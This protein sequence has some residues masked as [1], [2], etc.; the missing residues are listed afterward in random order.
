M[1]GPSS[2]GGSEFRFK[3]QELITS[4]QILD[5]TIEET[6]PLE[7]WQRLDDARNRLGDLTRVFEESGTGAQLAAS[8]RK[9]PTGAIAPQE[10]A[11]LE[12][13]PELNP[14][15]ILEL[16]VDGK[17]TY[18]NN[19]ARRLFPDLESRGI[20]HPYL[21]NWTDI[22][23]QATREPSYNCQH[24]AQVGDRIYLQ[25]VFFAL[26]YERIRIY[27]ME[28]TTSKQTEEELRLS[29]E[30]LNEQTRFPTSYPPAAT[31]GSRRVRCTYG[32]TNYR[33]PHARRDLALC[34]Y[35]GKQFRR[36]HDVPMFSP[37]WSRL[38][39]RRHATQTH[40]AIRQ[41]RPG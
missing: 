38:W 26:E 8:G 21:A 7:A 37:R 28:I 3:L 25:T 20:R 11:R 13:F 23:D 2:P 35:L 29:S 31:A 41:T 16:T 18:A 24:E 10:V 22:V 19:A 15:P 5:A 30:E 39:C 12:S 32:E 33:E 34:E 40:P 9:L 1:T 17:L 14:N 6:K 36:F 27:G 4:L